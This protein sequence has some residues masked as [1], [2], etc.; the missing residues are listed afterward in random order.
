MKFTFLKFNSH[1]NPFKVG[2]VVIPI[3]QM[4][5][6]RQITCP[7]SKNRIKIQVLSILLWFPTT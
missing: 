7:I 2:T 5:K 3:S 4:R 6:V 1:N